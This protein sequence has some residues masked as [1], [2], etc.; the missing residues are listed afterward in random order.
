MQIS[1][2]QQ[3]RLREEKKINAFSEKSQP[4]FFIQRQQ[5]VIPLAL[6]KIPD[7]SSDTILNEFENDLEDWSVPPK[8]IGSL[9]TDGTSVLTG[10]TMALFLNLRKTLPDLPC[11]KLC[12]SQCESLWKGFY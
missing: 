12:V 4:R 9:V 1:R 11:H 7:G 6:K 2:W 3:H 8:K 5:R 10:K